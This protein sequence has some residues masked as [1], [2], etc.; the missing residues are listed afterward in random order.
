MPVTM[1]NTTEKSKG[2][3]ACGQ[4]ASQYLWYA[5]KDGSYMELK[6]DPT[7]KR[8]LIENRY[9]HR[10]HHCEMT[11]KGGQVGSR[12]ESWLVEH[13]PVTWVDSNPKERG[14]T[15]E[16]EIEPVTEEDRYKVVEE[17]KSEVQR[18]TGNGG[19]NAAIEALKTALG[20][21][22][23]DETQVR[24]IVEDSYKEQLAAIQAKVDEALANVL[25][26]L[27]IEVRDNGEVRPVEGFAHKML[28]VVLR[29]LQ[30]R[31]NVWMVGP[32][33]GGKTTI[34]R[35]CAEALG[36]PYGSIGLTETRA[37]ED[38]IGYRGITGE[39]VET[40][41][42]R[43]YALC[44]ECSTREPETA[45]EQVRAELTGQRPVKY[46]EGKVAHCKHG[47]NGG[48]FLFDE[49]DRGNANTTL[50]VNEGIDNGSMAFPRG[51]SF[52]HPD[53]YIIAGANTYGSGANRL[54]VGAN[55]LDAAFLDRFVHVVVDY[56][57][58]LERSAC[59]ATGLE[60]YKV[61][62]VLS[63]MHALREKSWGL[64]LKVV[65]ASQRAAISACALMV[66][67][68]GFSLSEVIDM[69]VRNK[70]D[71]ADW[72]RVN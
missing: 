31:R 43:H 32:A 20:V 34:A 69:T 51:R 42:Y 53:C 60:E 17:I 1:Y 24:R 37:V 27:T 63:R 14:K 61:D 3:R 65:V 48:V 2:C 41:F 40:D 36:V 10:V 22:A 13:A 6:D 58:A 50:V 23:V 28:P 15:T 9:S 39:F 56:D 29:A 33:A 64:Q 67:D 12:A 19:A 4:G 18:A 21:Q 46:E 57:L 54:Y 8:I 5:N 66:G 38:I 45:Q 52:K 7:V 35:Q 47:F 44:E 26:P 62:Q 70:M 25:I 30:R 72:E 68:D 59:L 71:A 55:Q 49:C 16:P 11:Y